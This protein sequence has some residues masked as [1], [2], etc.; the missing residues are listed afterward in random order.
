[1]TTPTIGSDN[2]QTDERKE[3]LADI[4][5]LREALKVYADVDA[6]SVQFLA[7]FK[8]TSDMRDA[9]SIAEQALYET[10]KWEKGK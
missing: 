6:G 8:A 4:L 3:M 9:S 1:M 10:Q 7:G 5:K 2:T